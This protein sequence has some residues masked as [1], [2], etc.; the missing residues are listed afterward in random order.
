MGVKFVTTKISRLCVYSELNEYAIHVLMKEQQCKSGYHKNYFWY[1]G[2]HS[3]FTLGRVLHVVW[4]P[5][6]EWGKFYLSLYVC[7]VYNLLI[8]APA[9]YWGVWWLFMLPFPFPLY[10][11]ISVWTKRYFGL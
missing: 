1:D 8:M 3:S 11:A 10:R 5:E 6:N 7:M 4:R 2:P 9:V